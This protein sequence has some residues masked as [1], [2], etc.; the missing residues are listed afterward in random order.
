[1]FC[2]NKKTF[3]KLYFTLSFSIKSE[4]FKTKR[5]MAQTFNRLMSCAKALSMQKIIRKPFVLIFYLN[6]FCMLFMMC[7]QLLVINSLF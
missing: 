2:F 5:T 7:E 4:I 3:S 1:M 6:N